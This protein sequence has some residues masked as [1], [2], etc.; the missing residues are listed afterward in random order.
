MGYRDVADEE[1]GTAT[2]VDEL[3]HVYAPGVADRERGMATVVVLVVKLS[4]DCN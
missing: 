3:A 2:A 4:R 1:C